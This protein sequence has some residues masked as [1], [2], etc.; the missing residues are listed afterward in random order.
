MRPEKST[1][2]ELLYRQPEDLTEEDLKRIVTYYREER[3]KWQAKEASKKPRTK[4]PA[5]EIDFDFNNL[6]I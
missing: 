6:K 5:P 2:N 4:K 1:L 3:A